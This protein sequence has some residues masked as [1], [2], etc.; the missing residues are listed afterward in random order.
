MILGNRVTT[1]KVGG[2]L[3]ASIKVEEPH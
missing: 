3:S 2:R 1:G